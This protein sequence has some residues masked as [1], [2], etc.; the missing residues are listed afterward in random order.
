MQVVGITTQHE[1][2]IASKSHKFRMNEMLVIEDKELNE[3][4][5]EVVETLSYN[6][7]IPMGMDKG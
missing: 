7:Y 2:H 1:V 6:R 3:P 5:G 4:K